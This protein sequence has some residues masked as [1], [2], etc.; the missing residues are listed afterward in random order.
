M[1]NVFLNV[2][3]NSIKVLQFSFEKL[4]NRSAKKSA[5]SFERSAKRVPLTF[6][7]RSGSGSATQI[8]SNEWEWECHSKN[9]GVLNPLLI[10][11]KDCTKSIWKLLPIHF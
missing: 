4:G 3:R 6:R 2:I 5:H 8:C 1:R 11:L 9:K 7:L 10:V